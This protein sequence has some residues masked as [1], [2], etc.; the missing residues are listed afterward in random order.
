M[1]EH[2]ESLQYQDIPLHV[3]NSYQ[4]GPVCIDTSMRGSG[5]LEK[6]FEF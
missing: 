2:L 6:I 1:I 3:N 4:Y 5:L